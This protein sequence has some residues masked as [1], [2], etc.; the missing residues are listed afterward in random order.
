MPGQYLAW[1]VD[2]PATGDYAL[3]FRYANGGYESKR[4]LSVNGA[5]FNQTFIF[6]ATA[7]AV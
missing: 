3:T 7:A 2:A 4:K 1:S 5:P 6:P